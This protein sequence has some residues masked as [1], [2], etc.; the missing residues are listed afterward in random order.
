MPSNCLKLTFNPLITLP[1]YVAF[2]IIKPLVP[3]VITRITNILHFAY[4]LSNP[5]TVYGSFILSL[6]TLLDIHM[7]DHF[8]PQKFLFLSH[9][10]NILF[11]SCHIPSNVIPHS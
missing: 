8:N 11:H 3:T 4:A 5:T 7:V 1:N 9:L 6:I 2:T 10:P